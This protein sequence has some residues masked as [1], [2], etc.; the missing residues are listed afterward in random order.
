MTKRLHTFSLLFFT[1]EERELILS[2]QDSHVDT[3]IKIAQ[4]G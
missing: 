1:E 2:D 3:I 4:Y